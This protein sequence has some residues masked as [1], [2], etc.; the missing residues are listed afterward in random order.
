[1]NTLSPLPAPEKGSGISDQGSG[2]PKSNSNNLLQ[3]I[4]LVWELGWIIAV[5]VVI[6][7][8]GGA[9]LDKKW[10]T[11]PWLVLAGFAISFILSL[12]AAIQRVKEYLKTAP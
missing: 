6:L 9:W 1:M 12:A 5:P 10:G 11:A 8:F 7:G 4:G 3:G 2:S